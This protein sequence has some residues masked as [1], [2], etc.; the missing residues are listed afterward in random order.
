MKIKK[1]EIDIK[2]PRR[3]GDVALLVDQ[4]G[5]L[6]T[7]YKLRNK[8]N[9]KRLYEPDKYKSFLSY[10]RTF[11]EENDAWLL[12]KEDIKEIRLKLNRTP[13]FDKVIIFAVAFTKIPDSIYKT[14]YLKP[15]FN[16]KATDDPKDVEYAIVISPYTTQDEVTWE[17]ERF[18]KKMKKSIKNTR[19]GSH[20]VGNES[21][22]DYEY[23]VKYPP[24]LR[25]YPM[26][27]RGRECY[28]L[29]RDNVY[30]SENTKAK[31]RYKPILK[32]W[33]E[34]CPNNQEHKDGISDCIYCSAD[35]YK[36]KEN[37][38]SYR[39]LLRKSMVY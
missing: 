13:N 4:P 9:I 2:D 35:E 24:I 12:F 10:I 37:I 32:I 29:L 34:M 7:I 17:L 36:I 22:I 16:R 18:K 26:I 19:K 11:D 33:N 5:F 14:C 21:E 20:V 1:I 15:L 8:W 38:T 30:D 23:F 6:D 3:F 28:W 25:K 27:V 31:H 39:K